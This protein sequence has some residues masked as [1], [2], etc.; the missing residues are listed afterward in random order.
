MNR[1]L[2]IRGDDLRVDKFLDPATGILGSLLN[3]YTHG[4]TINQSTWGAGVVLKTF[5][6]PAQND[7]GGLPHAGRYFYNVRPWFSGKC[8]LV[9]VGAYFL[10]HGDIEKGV[11]GGVQAV[12]RYHLVIK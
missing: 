3:Q 7:T 12:L 2:V 5:E 4:E 1:W 9:W 10:P 11:E 8:G 6:E